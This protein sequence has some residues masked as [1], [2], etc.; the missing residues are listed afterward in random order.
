MEEIEDQAGM[1]M[2][3]AYLHF[4]SK[5]HNGKPNPECPLCKN[6]FINDNTNPALES[7]NFIIL[8]VS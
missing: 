8:D 4:Q 7:Y 3:I 5:G 1:M 2:D 6:F